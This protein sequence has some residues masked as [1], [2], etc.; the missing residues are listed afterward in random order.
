MHRCSASMA[1]FYP[2]RDGY[3]DKV[4]LG[5]TLDEKATVTIRAYSGS[6]ALKR[7]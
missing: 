6:G 3:K 4:A 1:T 2:S 5:G 7:T